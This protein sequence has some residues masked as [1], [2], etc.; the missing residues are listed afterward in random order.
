MLEEAF[1]KQYPERY[2]ERNHEKG[3]R[4]GKN[5]TLYSIEK[6]LAGNQMDSN[7]TRVGSRREDS[8]NAER[9]A[10]QH[11]DTVCFWHKRDVWL[12]WTGSHWQEDGAARV[13]ELAKQTARSIYHEAASMSEDAAAK[14]GQWA[15]R[16]LNC[17][18]ILDMLKLAKSDPRIAVTTDKLDSNQYL[19]NFENGTVDLRTGSSERIAAKTTSRRSSALNIRRASSVRDGCCSLS[20]C[21]AIWL[22][23]CRK[24]LGIRSQASLV[25]KLFSYCSDLPTP[26]KQRSSQH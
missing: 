19:L 16:T 22:T 3:D 20:K 4:N 8:S 1:R 24:P 18:K 15:E 21:L 13:V 14:M 6:F 5:Y 10:E 7:P 26:E 9:F 25:K 17:D 11:C 2:A 12:V 23:G